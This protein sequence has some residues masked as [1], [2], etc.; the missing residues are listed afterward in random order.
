MRSLTRS[1]KRECLKEVLDQYHLFLNVAAYPEDVRLIFFLTICRMIDRAHMQSD[2][3]S[4]SSLS[5][6]SSPPINFTAIQAN[7][8]RLFRRYTFNDRATE[9][10]NLEQFLDALLDAPDDSVAR[11]V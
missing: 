7:A 8:D 11:F 1:F 6:S 9:S 2:D 10:E 3:E 4:K 5:S